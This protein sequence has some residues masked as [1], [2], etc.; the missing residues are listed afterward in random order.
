MH[1]PA[2]A[3]PEKE[4]ERR[5][6]HMLRAHAIP[7]P[8]FNAPIHLEDRTYEVDCLWPDERLVV[9][10]DGRDAHMTAA[11]FE[12]DRVR[13]AALVAAGLRVIRITWRRL[14]DAEADTASQ[15]VALLSTIAD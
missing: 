11:A 9:E 1:K 7:P 10:L 14:H 5:F 8:Q 2:R 12:D 13:D 4:L 15:L 3:S 6:K